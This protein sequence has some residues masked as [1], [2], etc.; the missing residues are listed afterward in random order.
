MYEIAAANIS[1]CNILE[2]LNILAQKKAESCALL[3]V[4]CNSAYNFRQQRVQLLANHFCFFV[5][6]RLLDKNG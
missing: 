1:S 6:Q 5:F 2:V 3:T 4:I